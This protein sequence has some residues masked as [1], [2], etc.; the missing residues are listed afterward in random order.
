M[1]FQTKL[2]WVQ[3]PLRIRSDEIDGFIKI[4]AG[5]KHLVLFGS[6]WHNEILKVLDRSE[7]ISI[8]DSINQNFARIKIDS[9]TYLPIEK[10]VGD[11]C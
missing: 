10:M 9:Y 1:K 2:L 7:K 6:G 11:L 8:T 4:Y 3:K 5:I